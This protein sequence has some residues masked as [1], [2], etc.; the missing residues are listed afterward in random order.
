[1][2]TLTTGAQIVTDPATG[3]GTLVTPD[4]RVWTLNPSAVVALTE[5]ARGGTVADAELQLVHRW[6]DVPVARLRTDLDTL[7]G[8]LQEAGAVTYR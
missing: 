5:L 3:R 1:M 8:T 2:L 7:L 6:P 4:T